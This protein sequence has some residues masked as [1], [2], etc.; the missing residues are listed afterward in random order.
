MTKFTRFAAI[1]AAVATSAA[2]VAPANAAAPVTDSNGKAKVKIVKP[3]SLVGTGEI[4]FGT[5]VLPATPAGNSMTAV[6]SA[7]A[8]PTFSGCGA[9]FVCSIANGGATTNMAYN[10]TGTNNMNVIV[11]IPKVVAMAN[12]LGDSLNVDLST[13]IGTT[14]NDTATDLVRTVTMPNSGNT[15]VDFYVG[16]SLA[17]SDSAA[18]GDYNGTFDVTA[19]YE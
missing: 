3:L 15:G 9:T 19:E 13:N 7:A 4:D 17:V 5:I 12:G 10:V 1:A 6:V 2:L 18:E 16:G 14:A 11:T 8:S